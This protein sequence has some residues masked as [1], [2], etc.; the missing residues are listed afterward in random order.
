MKIDKTELERRKTEIRTFIKDNEQALFDW[1]LKKGVITESDIENNPDFCGW[2]IYSRVKGVKAVKDALGNVEIRQMPLLGNYD[3]SFLSGDTW[4]KTETKYREYD[5]DSNPSC[6][7]SKAKAD[8]LPD[9]T[10]LLNTFYDGAYALWTINGYVSSST[11][12]HRAKTAI[13]SRLITEECLHYDFNDN[14][15]RDRK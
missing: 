15:W 10:Y 3:F 11:W 9:D 7:L 12:T 8:K 5:W 6:A 13:N 2:E 14:I 1:G 4:I